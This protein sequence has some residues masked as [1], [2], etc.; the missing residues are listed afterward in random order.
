MFRHLYLGMF[1]SKVQQY[2]S[3]LLQFTRISEYYGSIFFISCLGL[4]FAGITDSFRI[5]MVVI[6][7]ITAVA[8]S[9]MF[10]DIED[11]EDDRKDSSKAARNPIAADLIGRGWAYFFCMISVI[12]AGLIYYVL[13]WPTF[14]FGF[15]SIA[16]SFLYS[17]KPIRIKSLPVIDVVAHAVQLGTTQ[18]FA[19][20]SLN[21]SIS[22]TIVLAAISIFF[23]SAIADINNELRDYDVD[24]AANLSN[25][26]SKFNMRVW[27]GYIQFGWLAPVFLILTVTLMNL[28][29]TAKVFTFLFFALI[30][31]VYFNSAP[32]TRRDHFFYV[33]S[34]QIAVIWGCILLFLR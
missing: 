12:V 9:F 10:N 27:T 7:N 13:G 34:Q 24:R 6:A 22:T 33:R 23:M 1:I 14:F 30:L 11:A 16:S 26:A 21:L 15:L 18:F 5:V 3:L 8:F 4:F 17:W 29:T 31:V 20:S 19:A 28:S 2:I 25:T 32:Q